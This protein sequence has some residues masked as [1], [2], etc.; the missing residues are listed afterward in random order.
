MNFKSFRNWTAGLFVTGSMVLG[1]NPTAAQGQIPPLFQEEPEVSYE[2]MMSPGNVP[3]TYARMNGGTQNVPVIRWQSNYFRRSGY[4][5]RNR[6]IEVS[7]RFQAFERADQLRHLIPTYA[8]ST[9]GAWYPVICTNT[10]SDSNRC[11]GLLIT[12]ELGENPNFVLEDLMQQAFK[13]GTPITR[14]ADG[15][16]S[17]DLDVYIQTVPSEQ[18]VRPIN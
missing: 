14:S 11:N 12:L 3:T 16:I 17:I 2:C 10:D 9:T 5:A 15:T 7:N 8:Q 4:S 6:C 13:E 18:N 1:L